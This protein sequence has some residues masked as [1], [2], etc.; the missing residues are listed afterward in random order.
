MADDTTIA[1]YNRPQLGVKPQHFYFNV[2][3]FPDVTFSVQT[4]LVPSVTLGVAPYDNPMQDIQLPGEKLTY[5]PLRMT[6]MMDEEFRTYTELYG[7]LRQFAFPDNRPDL[8]S[9]AYMQKSRPPLNNDALIPMCDC[10]LMV[11]DSANNPI[12]VFTFRY[13][14]PI[15]IGELQFDT[16]DDGTNFVKFDVEFAYTYF[17]VDTP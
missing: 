8:A 9:I 13:A 10:N 2:P 1:S 14:F 5:E 11:N 16:M 17:T 15:Y 6:L 7:W 3:M 12:V 4:A